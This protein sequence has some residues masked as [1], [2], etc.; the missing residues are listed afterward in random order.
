MAAIRHDENPYP[1][2]SSDGWNLDTFKILIDE[3]FEALNK[4]L[5]LQAAEY[6]RRLNELND[7]YSRIERIQNEYVTHNKYDDYIKNHQ[8][9]AEQMKE[10]L[11]QRIAN[12]YDE[13]NK[14]KSSIEK[15]IAV[16]QTE[17]IATKEFSTEQHRRGTRNIAIATIAIAIVVAV[18]NVIIHFL[19]G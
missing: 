5:V 11:H 17:T 4:A 7:E 8:I 13:F 3:R 16:Q 6:E 10:I 2:Y 9:W 18:T 14:F 19:G 1:P 12:V 15:E